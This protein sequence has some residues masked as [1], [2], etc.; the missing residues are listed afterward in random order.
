[1]TLNQV[2]TE[3]ELVERSVQLEDVLATGNFDE[4]CRQKADQMPDQHGRYVWY[5]LKANFDA[6]P[7]REMLNLLGK[8]FYLYRFFSNN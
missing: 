7:R 8:R 2:V 4:Y 1:M 5:F 3:T 6:D